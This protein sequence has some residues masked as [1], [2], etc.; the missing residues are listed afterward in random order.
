MLDALG[1]SAAAFEVRC[2]VAPAIGQPPDA[3]P[4]GGVV[5]AT[6]RRLDGRDGCWA[7]TTV[8]ADSRAMA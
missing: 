8:M 2:S 5:P 3:P 4:V 1:T 7:T 6:T